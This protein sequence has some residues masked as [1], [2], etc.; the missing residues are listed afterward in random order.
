MNI[1]LRVY[2]SNTDSG[3]KIRVYC[4]KDTTNLYLAFI[5]RNLIFNYFC[6]NIQYILDTYFQLNNNN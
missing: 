1:L 6:C 5:V 4:Y 3:S 2:A